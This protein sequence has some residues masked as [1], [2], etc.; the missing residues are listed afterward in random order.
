MVTRKIH[1]P[2]YGAQL[3]IV[4]L[5]DH[6][7]VLRGLAHHLNRESDITVLAMFDNSR[8]LLDYLV[9][10]SA[11]LE[12][13][14]YVLLIDYAL[15]PKDVDGV[16]LIRRLRIKFPASR[17]LV[18]SA[19]H[20]PSLVK[21]AIMAGA[22]GYIGKERPL[23]ELVSAIRR[24]AAGESYVHP[25]L[26]DR[27]DMIVSASSERGKDGGMPTNLASVLTPR[28]LEVLRL[29]MEGSEVGK[30][31]AKLNRSNK[32]IST[33]KMSA[34]RKLGILSDAE[35]FKLKRDLVSLER[36]DGALADVGRCGE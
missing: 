20:Q 22:N 35:L 14:N 3:G 19:H 8:E 32:T 24:V 16:S 10:K 29:V 15:G 28:E 34:Y 12:H 27:D 5:D 4:L 18:V 9:R 6:E 31:A 21:L 1:V 30:I 23:V 33:Q 7:V 17:L 25:S 36:A 11:E 13:V 2:K 26:S